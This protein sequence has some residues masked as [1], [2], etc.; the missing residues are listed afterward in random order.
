MTPGR[1][2]LPDL[3]AYGAVP[4]PDMLALLRSVTAGTP[5]T[6]GARALVAVACAEGVDPGLVRLLPLLQDNPAAAALPPSIH[7]AIADSHRLAKLR[8]ILMERAARNL[9]QLFAEAGITPLFLKGFA[10]A[11]QVYE[12][13]ALR[14]MG[15]LDLA[16]PDADFARAAALL[17]G[18]G[19]R[20]K[21][22]RRMG[23]GPGLHA[24]TFKHAKTG[25]IVDLHRF[26]L[27]CSRWDG[28]DA[29]FWARALP[30]PVG[31]A[32][33][34]TLAPED[35]LLHGCLHGHARN[36]LQSPFRWMVDAHRILVHSGAGFRWDVLLEEVAR[37]RCGGVLAATLGFLAAEL[38][39][40]VPPG[41]PAALAAT[42]RR[43]G[44][45]GYFRLYGTMPDVPSVALRARALWAS[46]RRQETAPRADPIR[47][48]RWLAARWERGSLAGAALETLR[49]LPRARD[50]R[51]KQIRGT[52]LAAH[53]KALRSGETMAPSCAGLL[54]LLRPPAP[55][56]EELD[57][58]RAAVAS[59]AIA[60]EAWR[61]CGE[62]IAAAEASGSPAA[63]PFP[64]RIRD[65]LPLIAD[66]TTG[67]DASLS[68][69]L[70][71]KLKAAQLLETVRQ[72]ALLALAAEILANPAM[73]GAD[74]I[75][76]GG[77]GFAQA[78]YP[79]PMLR[80]TSSLAFL[81]PSVA[82]A[83]EAARSLASGGRLRGDGQGRGG[84]FRLRHGSGMA[85]TLHGGACPAPA[86]GFTHARLRATASRG[87]ANGVALLR[88][89]GLDALGLLAVGVARLP[90]GASLLWLADA[91]LA[92]RILAV[93]AAAAP[94]QNPLLPRL[95]A[96][97]AAQAMSVD[98]EAGLRLA[99]A[100]FAGGSAAEL[101]ESG[102][103]AAT[104]AL[105][106]L[107]RA[108]AAAP[109]GRTRLRWM[110]RCGPPAGLR[111]L[112]R[113]AAAAPR[114]LA[115]RA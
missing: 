59:P 72:Q 74:P 38:G 22:G 26:V 100:G 105:R 115:G 57:Y 31:D 89:G 35:H 56:A 104:V 85:V 82:L 55:S 87:E 48:L 43:P 36:V 12:S 106:G 52:A 42:K 37:Q 80:H 47:F 65:L 114:A 98:P 44:D 70:A 61:R 2:A 90:A 7:T 4:D 16:V 46:Y 58:V 14:P 75:L 73:R 112:E 84:T 6:D 11:S 91:V 92:A 93:G 66:R 50:A 19:Y 24:L 68:P 15:D 77:L 5:L 34:R 96:E 108:L 17:A 113:L 76:L 29:G 99:Q 10:L 21:P 103:L 41:I 79:S 86:D 54:A 63:S 20:E 107:R 67:L 94:P 69:W 111:R 97:L 109:D 83:R 27:A 8:F 32:T 1:A 60:V 62:R 45:D 102:L 39:A 9:A 78:A 49:R 110:L 25:E 95:M 3:V 28:A 18:L 88:A 64:D 101:P 51:S 81:L 40:P 33:A 23:L 13:P 30:M 71:G 53:T